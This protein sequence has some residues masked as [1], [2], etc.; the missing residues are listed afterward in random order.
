MV[1][2]IKNSSSRENTSWRG[3][4]KEGKRKSEA[5]EVP[6][7]GYKSVRWTPVCLADW[8]CLEEDEKEDEPGQEV[9]A[10]C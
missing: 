2:D 4:E 8:G 7:A 6:S 9:A 10:L 3:A 5:G 1:V